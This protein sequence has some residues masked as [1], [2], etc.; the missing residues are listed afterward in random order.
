MRKTPRSSN[1]GKLMNRLEKWSKNWKD[2]KDWKDLP[3]TDKQLAL[4]ATLGCNWDIDEKPESR[5]YASELIDEMLREPDEYEADWW[6][7]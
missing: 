1:G 7:D 2:P 4:L 6:R 3:P 5:G